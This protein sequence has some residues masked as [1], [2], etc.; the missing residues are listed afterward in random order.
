MVFL[1]VTVGTDGKPKD[2]IVVSAPNP[3][4]DRA[5]LNALKNWRFSPAHCGKEPIEK[6]IEVQMQFNTF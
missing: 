5:A 3:D 6:S 4:F 2:L 1:S